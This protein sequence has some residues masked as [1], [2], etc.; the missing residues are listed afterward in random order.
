[1]QDRQKKWDTLYS[2]VLKPRLEKSSFFYISLRSKTTAKGS[3]SESWGG[4]TAE[5][6]R[7]CG[8]AAAYQ[9][10]RASPKKKDCGQTD[11]IRR[12]V[13]SYN[14]PRYWVS[15]NQRKWNI[16]NGVN[17]E[18]STFGA[19]FKETIK[20]KKNDFTPA[21]CK[22]SDEAINDLVEERE[23]QGIKHF[24]RKRTHWGNRCAVRVSM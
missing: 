1:M 19:E 3:Q 16:G 18:P 20:P 10:T 7:R 23:Q 17:P 11:Q 8:D 24:S 21:L 9:S 12:G 13:E 15:P 4:Q 22:L 5:G 6:W 14:K 2:R